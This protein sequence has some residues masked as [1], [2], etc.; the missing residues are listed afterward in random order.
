MLSQ[1]GNLDV[2]FF[3]KPDFCDFM[4][5]INEVCCIKKELHILMNRN[6]IGSI[7]M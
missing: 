2:P 1:E 4:L 5:K 3:N 7:F 6:E